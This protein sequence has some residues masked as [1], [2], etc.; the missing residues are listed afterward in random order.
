MRVKNLE[1][2]LAILTIVVITGLYLAVIPL[3]GIPAASGLVGHGIGILGFLLMVMTEVLYSL[4]KRYRLA[5]WG[6]MRH[7]LSFHIFTGIVGPYMVLLHSSW[8]FNGLAGILMLLTV[9]IVLSGFIGRYFYTAVPRSADGVILEAVQL[10]QME[11]QAQAA[12][13]QALAAHP[14]LAA[15]VAGLVGGAN[16]KK[17]TRAQRRQWRQLE[18][19][20]PQPQRETLVELR[21]LWER[22]VVLE[23]QLSAL[24][25]TRKML[26]LWHTVHIPIGVVLFTLAFI[27]MGAALYYATFIH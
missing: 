11:S 8:K 3:I 24:A 4:R 17:L 13:E 16:Q 18:K 14:Q 25:N 9:I 26:A 19:R 21:G 22:Q 7:W 2:W 1:L 10:K 15:E 27:H 20:A 6:K 5:R 12:L 23:R